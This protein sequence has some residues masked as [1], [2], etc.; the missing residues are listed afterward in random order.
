MFPFDDVIII[1]IWGILKEGPDVGFTNACN[2]YFYP[3]WEYTASTINTRLGFLEFEYG[4]APNPSDYEFGIGNFDW[5]IQCSSPIGKVEAHTH[6]FI[7]NAMG[8]YE[9]CTWDTINVLMCV[10]RTMSTSFS[11][12]IANYQMNIIKSIHIP[13]IKLQCPLR[14]AD[15]FCPAL[16]TM[17][18]STICSDLENNSR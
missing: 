8:S 18:P 12:I 7:H 2:L 9:Y 4:I 3:N 10:V 16:Y 1:L 14:E 5:R 6:Y 15:T 13:Y 17:G 11:M